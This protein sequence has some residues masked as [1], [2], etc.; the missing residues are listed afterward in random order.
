[1]SETIIMII[2][3]TQHK[4][5]MNI[6]V[7][8][9]FAS[10][11][12]DVMVEKL[13]KNT[14][15]QRIVGGNGVFDRTKLTLTYSIGQIIKPIHLRPKFDVELVAYIDNIICENSKHTSGAAL[16]IYFDHK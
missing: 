8:S 13:L 12:Y 16:P 5:H 4:G 11:I 9:L 1:M 10:C 6:H 14:K 15:L 3:K 7:L 2:Q